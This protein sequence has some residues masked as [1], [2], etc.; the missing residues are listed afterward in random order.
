MSRSSSS[1]DRRPALVSLVVAGC[2]AAAWA[3]WLGWDQ[4]RDVH[5]DGSVTGPYEAWQVVGLVLTLFVPACWAT[6]RG[7]SRAA[8]LGTTAGLAVAAGYD[9]S[10]DASGLFMVGVTMLVMGS[11]AG[12][13]LITGIVN[14]V[15]GAAHGWGRRAA[16]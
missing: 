4:T 1:A 8:V 12:T 11:L 15:H 6:L 5:P 3:V 13:A 9:W 16:H 2:A 14:A 7:H 10:D